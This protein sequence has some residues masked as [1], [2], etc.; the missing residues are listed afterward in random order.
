MSRRSSAILALIVLGGLAALRWAFMPPA[1]TVETARTIRGPFAQTVDQD[2]ITRVRDHYVV[3]APLA[4]MLLRPH[5]EAGDPVQREQ[6]LATIIPS[7]PQMLD[8]RTHA[9]LVARLAAADA[10][11]KRAGALVLQAQSAQRQTEIDTKRIEDLAAQN[12]VSRTERERAALELDI[13]RRELE[14]AR[15][16]QDAAAHD[17]QQARAALSLSQAAGAGRAK[18]AW[19]VRAPVAGVVLRVVQESE[20]VVSPGTPIVE[21]GDTGRLQAIIDVLSSEA[22]QIHV[23]APVT[24]TA[25]E[26]VQLTG[27]VREIEPGAFTK[28]STLGVE[29][30]R[31]NIVVELLPDPRLAG[32]IGDGY[33]VEAAIEIARTDGA[34]QVP[35]AALFREGQS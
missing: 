7:A 20:G 31:V 1:I 13:R 23:Q 34:V 15:F 8:P 32:R 21:I 24:L 5:L 19:P 16:E 3:S 30:Q 25:G 22:T 11:L 17:Q 6:L 35:V 10:R 28:I 2:G 33:R 9:E 27:R 12:F 29:E 26:G 18:D 14:A 4:G